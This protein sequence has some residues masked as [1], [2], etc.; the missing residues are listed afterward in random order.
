MDVLVH[1]RKKKGRGGG[2]EQLPESQPWRRRFGV[3]FMLTI[4]SS[5]NPPSS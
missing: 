5:R 3:C 1:L 4:G 2:G